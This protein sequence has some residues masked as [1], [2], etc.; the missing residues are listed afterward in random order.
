[1]LTHPFVL[2]TQGNATYVDYVL[3]GVLRA[4]KIG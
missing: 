2:Y 4:A 1:M 3:R